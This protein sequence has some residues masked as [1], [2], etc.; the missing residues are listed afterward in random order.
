MDDIAH[1]FTDNTPM[2][3]GKH[4]GKAMANVPADYLVW[5]YE[6]Y[7][8]MHANLKEYIRSNMDALKIEAANIKAA[9]KLNKNK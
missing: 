3:F 5:I 2:P 7:D 8:N 6:N 1:I 4:K 9:Y